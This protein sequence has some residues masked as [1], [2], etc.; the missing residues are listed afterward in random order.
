MQVLGD[1]VAESVA[2][3]GEDSSAEQQR[4]AMRRAF[5]ALMS[6]DP[7]LVKE[8]VTSLVER[9]GTCPADCECVCVFVCVCV[10]VCV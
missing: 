7:G 3:L 2:S 4:T 9:L 5:S 6:A 8:E 10:C 1:G